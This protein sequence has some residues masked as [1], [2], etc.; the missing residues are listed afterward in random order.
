M[1]EKPAHGFTHMVVRDAN[2]YH[3]VPREGDQPKGVFAGGTDVRLLDEKQ[4][5]AHVRSARDTGWVSREHLEPLFFELTHE[6]TRYT[7]YYFDEP[8]DVSTNPP[9][10]YLEAGTRVQF[11]GPWEVGSVYVRVRWTEAFAAVINGE[12]NPLKPL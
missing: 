4:G 2:Y 6:T 8:F 9:D 10:G 11:L 5:Y 1:A 3:R 7:P 12:K